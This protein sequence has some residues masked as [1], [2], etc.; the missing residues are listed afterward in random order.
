M[1]AVVYLTAGKTA[2]ELE[3][4]KKVTLYRGQPSEYAD[5]PFVPSLL[6]GNKV[7]EIETYIKQE[8]GTPDL[9][10][11]Q[12]ELSGLTVSTPSCETLHKK[13]ADKDHLY[14]FFL[15]LVNIGLKVRE[16]PIFEVVS[17]NFNSDYV[18][19]L[20]QFLVCTKNGIPKLPSPDRVCSFIKG[21]LHMDS[22]FDG[23]RLRDYALFHHL[24][25]IFPGQFP[26]LLLDWTSDIKTAAFFSKDISG[27]HGTVVSMEYRNR[28]Y[29]VFCDYP[30][31]THTLTH[32]STF[33]NAVGYACDNYDCGCESKT[34]QMTN[35]RCFD[36]QVHKTYFMFRQS[37]ITLQQGT[38]LYWPYRCNLNQ[39]DSELKDD[40]GFNIF[41]PKE[42]QAKLREHPKD[43]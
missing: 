39:L 33:Y 42:L 4:E 11:Y 40:L 1:E 7:Q 15:S 29:D 26:T 3:M 21:F 19:F 28:L 41:R 34:V 24:N 5:K 43:V 30:G 6:R 10:S 37:L 23:K 12:K 13:L 35:G 31:A 22:I 36:F 14:Y 20:K 8:T 27:E 38:C 2:E 18:E 25:F 9:E 17:Q 32:Q 16:N